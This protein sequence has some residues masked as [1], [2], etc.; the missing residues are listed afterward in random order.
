MSLKT[1][2]L[3]IDLQ[4][5]FHEITGAALAV[6]GSVEDT[7]RICTLI[8]K[9]NPDTIYASQDTHYNL[10]ISHAA[11]W[12]DHQGCSVGPFTQ[13]TAGDVLNGKYVP[14]M[15]PKRSLKYLQDLETNGE[16]LHMIWPDHCIGGT[17][18]HAFLPLFSD[19]LKNWTAKNKKWYNLITKGV[20]PWTEHFGVFRANVPIPQDPNTDVDQRIFKTLRDHDRVL[21]SGQARTHCD[22]NSL[23]QLLEIAPDLAPK[24]IILED[25]MSNVAGLPPDFYAHVDSLY[26][27]AK[28]M[29]VQFART[30]DI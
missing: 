5:D 4:C 26:A 9:L 24:V 2:M 30:T 3:L 22:I 19:T 1:A 7:K 27:N 23:K 18:G 13:I 14:R 17:P 20:N 25:G 16:F 10:D 21:L 8:E 6:P 11:W 28:A 12:N 15:D 29:G